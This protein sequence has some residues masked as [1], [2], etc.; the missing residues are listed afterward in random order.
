MD[1]GEDKEMKDSDAN[2]VM[3]VAN[4]EWKTISLYVS[5]LAREPLSFETQIATL[6]PK[7]W[8]FEFSRKKQ[9][10]EKKNT[11]NIS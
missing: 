2:F 5:F 1:K 7:L 4:P 11:Y 3:G 8:P 10:K 9:L 6:R